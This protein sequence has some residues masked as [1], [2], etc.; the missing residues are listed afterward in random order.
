MIEPGLLPVFRGY[1]IL[2]VALV[3]LVIAA[4]VFGPFG[5]R[6]LVVE[7]IPVDEAGMEERLFLTN[8]LAIDSTSVL[9][10][11]TLLMF[12]LVF[13]LF[14]TRT[15]EKLGKLYLPVGIFI[16][17]LALFLEQ[18]LFTPFAAVWQP[19]SFLFIL[20]ILVAWQY[21]M[22]T[23]LLFAVT[24]TLA[25]TAITRFVRPAMF[26]VSTVGTSQPFD[27]V[28]F[29]GRE[30]GRGLSFIV[31]GFVVVS[32]MNA[33][34]KQRKELA[35]ANQALVQH[36]GTLEQLATSRERNRLSR[37]LHDTVAHTLSALTVQ[38][39]ALETAWQAMPE[40]AAG[41]VDKMLTATRNGLNETRRTLKNLRA[42]PLEELGLALA[43]QALAQDA[44]ARH[45]LGL[46]LEIDEKIIEITPEMEQ[47]FYRVAQEAIENVGRHA[48]AK[49]LE[50]RLQEMNGQLELAI[51]DDGRGFA[52][53]GVRSGERIGVTSMRERAELI[54]ATFSI[55]SR[56]WQGTAI[57]MSVSVGTATV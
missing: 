18:Y 56:S 45:H 32:L 42:A 47:A 15:L 27:G 52:P 50:V 28:M 44:A 34:R 7:N 16:A 6:G 38:L 39:E 35:D 3:A 17:A 10:I 30:T 1:A 25:E 49:V 43:V 26:F 14:S 37:E 4:H 5:S 54:G 33:Q 53:E 36:A 24:V 19:E 55:E 8:P 22:L 48:S 20:L 31:V 9:V 29:F 23:V 40:K 12:L 21:N 51:R 46:K 41:M 13:Y 11:V 57:R 2:R